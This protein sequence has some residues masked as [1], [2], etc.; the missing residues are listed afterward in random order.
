MSAVWA[1]AIAADA[2]GRT[3]EVSALWGQSAA[4]EEH[5]QPAAQKLMHS[6]KNL[7]PVRFTR[8]SQRLFGR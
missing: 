8:G 1:E 6:K 5:P 4:P 3:A 7:A 2:L